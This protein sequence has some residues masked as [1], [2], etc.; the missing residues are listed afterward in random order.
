[1]SKT[2]TILLSTTPYSFEN[3]HTAAKI[4]EAALAKGHEVTIFASGDGV[5][6]FT[7]GQKAKGIPNASDVF[8]KLIEKGLSV[9]LC[10]TCLVFRG[11]KEDTHL[12][13]AN[14]STLK[15]LFE[16]TRKSDVFVNLGM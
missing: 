7:K 3:T 14:P 16:I 5:H 4:A 2:I 10:G 15:K 1:M 13:G 8:S 6:N 12:D 11:I 9:E